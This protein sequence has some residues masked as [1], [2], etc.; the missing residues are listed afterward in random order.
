MYP[1]VQPTATMLSPNMVL[2][3]ESGLRRGASVVAVPWAHAAMT[4]FLDETSPTSPN[5][6][7]LDPFVHL[8]TCIRVATK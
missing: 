4:L 8:P 5:S 1:P 7:L 6:S 3:E 2:Y